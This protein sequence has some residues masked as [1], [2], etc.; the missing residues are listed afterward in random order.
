MADDDDNYYNNGYYDDGN[1]S[2]GCPSW[3]PML[4]FMGCASAVILANLGG[5]YGT[6]KA[7]LGLMSMGIR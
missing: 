5:A 6:A 3:A 4:G 2:Y 7:G 1:V